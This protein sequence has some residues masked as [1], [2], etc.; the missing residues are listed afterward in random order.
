M[1]RQYWLHRVSYEGGLGIL[2]SEKKL[3]IG[4]SDAAC[5]KE[6]DEA[7][8]NQDYESFC[9]AYKHVYK[10]N[11]E[12][13]KKNLWRFV[14]EMQ[15]DDVVVVPCPW[16]FYL[17]KITSDAQKCNRDGLDLGWERNVE[18]LG[19]LRSPRESYARSGLLSR[20]KCRQTTLKIDDLEEDVKSALNQKTPFDFLNDAAK[21]LLGEF[22]SQGTPEGFENY[23]A[24]CFENM[25]AE[26]E[27]LSRNYS[28]K[29][30]D[31]DVEAVF[32]LLKLVVS[33]QCKRHDGETGI[34]GIDQIDMY[35]ARA[36]KEYPEGWMFQKWVVTTA[37]EF[38]NEAVAKA[39]NKNI[40]LVHGDEFCKMVL[41][42]GLK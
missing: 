26:V 37:E 36:R 19:N 14:E 9:N 28:G 22:K 3:T 5:S 29:V 38:S 41:M 31:C 27:I 39:K 8:A 16:G 11:I 13:I 30:G 17:C 32:P 4:Y 24:S 21:V 15:K 12:R 10:G 42:V 1:E 7:I 34:Q 18:F 33:V 6:I 20:M 40:R 2:K 35:E 25:G 23:V